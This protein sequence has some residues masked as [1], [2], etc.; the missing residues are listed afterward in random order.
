MA[1][2]HR[3]PDMTREH[4]LRAAGAAIRR[5]RRAALV[6]AAIRGRACARVSPTTVSGWPTRPPIMSTAPATW[7]FWMRRCRSSKAAACAPDEHDS[8]FQPAIS[9]ETRQ[10][11]S[12]IAPAPS[13]TAS[14]SGAHGLPLMGTGDWNDGMNRVG[15]GARARASGWLVPVATLT[16]FRAAGRGARRHEPRHDGARMPTQLQTALER[17]AWDGEWYRRALFRRRHAAGFADERSN[18][19]SIP[20]P[21]PG[22]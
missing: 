10:P 5:R 21:S 17:E 1:L 7:R 19:G 4:M 11:C 3:R 20:S 18:A 14:T 16:A 9:D 13:T 2:V 8:F 6:A 22:P 15:K 12:S